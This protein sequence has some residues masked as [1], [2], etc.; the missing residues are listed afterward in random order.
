MLN[1]SLQTT[2]SLIKLSAYGVS[3]PS[4][5]ASIISQPTMIVLAQL[6]SLLTVHAHNTQHNGTAFEMHHTIDT[7]IQCRLDLRLLPCCASQQYAASATAA[8]HMHASAASIYMLVATQLSRH[9]TE[10]PRPGRHAFTRMLSGSQCRTSFQKAHQVL[11]LV[12]ADGQLCA[13]PAG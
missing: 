11:T 7:N 2:L 12:K 9:M 13:L 3:T 8:A 1:H 4:W 10:A 6:R 5:P